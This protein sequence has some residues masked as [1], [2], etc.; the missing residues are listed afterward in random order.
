MMPVEEQELAVGRAILYAER[1]GDTREA[2][3]ARM[4]LAMALYYGP[5][6]CRRPSVG[7]IKSWRRRRR[8]RW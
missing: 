7:V 4:R 8:T 1:A 6:P 2:T 3:W 5:T